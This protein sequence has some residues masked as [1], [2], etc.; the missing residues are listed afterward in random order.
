[1][2]TTHTL[3]KS[4]IETMKDLK[5]GRCS[6]RDA[7][8]VSKLASQIVYSVRIELEEKRLQLK[9]NRS[10]PA[11]MVTTT[12]PNITSKVRV[13]LWKKRMTYSEV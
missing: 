6:V 9:H 8:A 4:L 12:I 11:N 13:L 5:E 2:A 1:M 7:Q 10:V 3:R